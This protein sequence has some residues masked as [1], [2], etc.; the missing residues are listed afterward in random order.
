[1][2]EPPGGQ[3]AADADQVT[4]F[5]AETIA[6]R[7]ARAGAWILIAVGIGCILFGGIFF[8]ANHSGHNVVATVTH[9]GRARTARAPWTWSTAPAAARSRRSCTACPAAR[10]TVPPGLGSTSPTS[11]GPKPIPR[12][13]TCQ[14]ASGLALGLLGSPSWVGGPGCG[15][16]GSAPRKSHGGGRGRDTRERGGHG[17]YGTSGCRSA[18]PGWPGADLRARPT[19]G[20]RHIGRYHHRRT[21]S[22]LVSGYLHAPGRHS[23][24]P[25]GYA[26]FPEFAAP[27]P[28]PGRCRLPGH[29][30]GSIDLGLFPGL[31]DRAA[32]RRRRRH[33]A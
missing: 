19:V 10:S 28:P 8:A 18:S 11:P 15:Y 24:R 25:H 1:M 13:M 3:A 26:E 7:E 23:P 31:A 33:G 16:G 27:Q 9:Q 29:R 4:R 21:L 5:T 32:A 22:P 30:R 17:R 6:A 14:M 12:P 2:E 20:C